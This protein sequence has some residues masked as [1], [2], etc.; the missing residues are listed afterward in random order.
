MTAHHGCPPAMQGRRGVWNRPY[1]AM[2]LV[3]RIHR[4]IWSGDLARLL[5]SLR[6]I[7]HISRF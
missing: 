2:L 7:F 4:M 5:L 6:K 1:L 3:F